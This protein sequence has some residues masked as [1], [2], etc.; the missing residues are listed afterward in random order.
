MKKLK[1]II[2]REV[3]TLSETE[4]KQVLGGDG[5]VVSG[6]CKCYFFGEP[7]VYSGPSSDVTVASSREECFALCKAKCSGISGC[8]SSLGLLTS[9]T[10][11]YSE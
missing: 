8:T 10:L 6:I 2:L 11:P 4:M 7:L 5:V 3:P 9:V 1:K